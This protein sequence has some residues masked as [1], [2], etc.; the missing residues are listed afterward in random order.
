MA[1]RWMHIH[2]ILPLTT[3]IQQ[4]I[5][6]NQMFVRLSIRHLHLLVWRAI[7]EQR[8][9]VDSKSG[10]NLSRMFVSCDKMW[11]ED[12]MKSGDGCWKYFLNKCQIWKFFYIEFEV[13]H[14]RVSVKRWKSLTHDYI[15]SIS[16]ET[17]VKKIKKIK[18]RKIHW[19]ENE[20]TFYILRFVESFSSLQGKW[21]E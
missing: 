15:H 5:S 11:H 6:W 4:I 8:Q 3:E 12:G 13:I 1:K 14:T 18:Q 10:S 7:F 2:V 17:S 9:N 19:K 16:E 21:D 20:N